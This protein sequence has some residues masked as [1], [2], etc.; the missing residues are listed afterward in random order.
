MPSGQLPVHYNRVESFMNFMNE[1][2]LPLAFTLDLLFGD[3]GWISHPVQWIGRLAHITEERLRGTRLPLRLAGILAVIIV[4]GG[5]AG[6][7]WLLIAIASQLHR[8]AGLAVSIYLLYSSFAVRS[9]GDHAGA[10]QACA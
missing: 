6:S 1:F 4:V 10:V 7:A 2:I 3:P 8:V 5:S 9:L